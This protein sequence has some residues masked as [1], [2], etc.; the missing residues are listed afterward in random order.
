MNRLKTTLRYLA[1]LAWLAALPL[2]QAQSGT[3]SVSISVTKVDVA[4]TYDGVQ[5]EQTV[6]FQMKAL[7]QEGAV[8]V[9]KFSVAQNTKLQHFKLHEAYTL[10]QDGQKI[11]LGDADIKVQDG[12]VAAGYGVA[13]QDTKITQGIF[14]NVAVGD[15]VYYRYTLTQHTPLLPGWHSSS[16]FLAPNFD[17]LDVTYT[18]KALKGAK[19]YVKATGKGWDSQQSSDGDTQTWVFKTASKASVSETDWANSLQAVPMVAASSIENYAELGNRYAAIVEPM[20]ASTPELLRLSKSIVGDS[21]TPADKTKKLYDWVRKNIRYVATY[22]GAGG[23]QPH[24]VDWILQNKYGD[25]KD[26]VLLLQ[27]LLKAQGIDSQGALINTQAEYVLP[28]VA[29]GSFNHIIIYVPSLNL[30]LDPTSENVP[31][32][33]LTQGDAGRPVVLAAL[34]A[35]T[36]SRTP[37]STPAQR[38]FSAQQTIKIDAAGKGTASFK[39]SG[40]G[41]S[42]IDIRQRMKQIPAGMSG[43]AVSRILQQSGLKGTGFLRYDDTRVESESFSAEG[44]LNLQDLL[45][46]N[47]SGAISPHVFT[48]GLPMYPGMNNQFLASERRTDMVCNAS[49]VSNSYEVSFEGFNILRLPKD[50]DIKSEFLDYTATYQ[51]LSDTSYKGAVRLVKKFTGVCTPEQYKA[52]RPFSEQIVQNMRQ[53]VLYAKP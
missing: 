29:I 23:W 3:P 17:Y 16:G 33:Q 46:S 6:A 14:P 10:K 53:Q 39:L 36:L 24:T 5:S 49:D 45:P 32:P 48:I 20:M 50:L 40:Q 26:H 47:E 18:Y 35:S 8:G 1:C 19:L 2:A 51:K 13:Q 7:T 25:C 12:S 4:W 41:L 52:I 11:A 9:G 28:A 44:D 42:A 37:A 34:N 27:A 38:Q 21:V 22:L 30:F 31:Y 15:S 43:S